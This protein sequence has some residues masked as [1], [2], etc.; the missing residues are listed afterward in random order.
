ML[1]LA[2]P[3]GEEGELP[4]Q[5]SGGLR[6]L[7]E[8]PAAA[9]AAAAAGRRR[10]RSYVAAGA[11]IALAGGAG[12]VW[13]LRDRGAAP[14]IAEHADAGGPVATGPLVPASASAPAT[15]MAAG[16]APSA[17]D[18]AA[19]A[20]PP[21]PPEAKGAPDPRPERP[22]RPDKPRNPI[23][24]GKRLLAAH[25]YAAARE[26]FIRAR[27]SG[28]GRAAALT[29]LGEVAFQEGEFNGALRQAQA[30]VRAGGGADAHLLLGN[31]FFR[32]GRYA[33]A[34]FEY[35]KVLAQR[36]GHAEARRNL[37]AAQKRL[38]GRGP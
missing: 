37:E 20:R 30:A 28:H 13:A 29:G 19:E 4:L 33:E 16:A 21:A 34:I 3:T 15:T 1:G 17:A 25:R 6:R 9:A 14:G 26:A 38:G 18:A 2:P 10:W 7:P 35:Q 22:D 12:A 32:L 36:R 24:E 11:I 8:L 31:C 23:I 27:D 5:V